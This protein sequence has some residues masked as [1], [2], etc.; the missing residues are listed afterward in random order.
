MIID[1]Y[2]NFNYRGEY[3]INPTLILALIE[4]VLGYTKVD[5]GSN[6]WIFRHGTGFT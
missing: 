5:D 6:Y 3:T 1:S 2:L 4:G